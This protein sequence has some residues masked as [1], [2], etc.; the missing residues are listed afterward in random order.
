LPSCWLRRLAA[1]GVP[2]R[3]R[4][5]LP[6]Q[7]SASG[8]EI[9]AG[10]SVDMAAL[11]SIWFAPSLLERGL[12]RHEPCHDKHEVRGQLSAY[13]WNNT[14]GPGLWKWSHYFDVYEEHLGRIQCSK[15]PSRILEMGV[16]SG[17]SLKMWR[18]FFGARARIYALDISPRTKA[19]ERNDSYGAPNA[20]FVGSQADPAVWQQV[21]AVEKQLD[22]ILDDAA[23]TAE[24]QIASLKLGFK[25][26]AA[27][28]VYIVEDLAMDTHFSTYV[29]RHFVT[30]DSGGVM[31]YKALRQIV[32]ERERQEMGMD[33]KA[34]LH[35]GSTA[36][37]VEKVT[38]H[39]GIAV[40]TK[41]R[42]PLRAITSH[43]L[44]SVWEPPEFWAGQPLG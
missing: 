15:R 17:G 10:Q 2:L 31:Q 11:L 35:S 20:V 33:M 39:P 4:P 38:F 29:L 44:G 19:F 28:G 41:R 16:Y 37:A 34:R 9:A 25:L 24:L 32:S 22:V 18:W 23:H 36:S 43:R 8:R 40:I 42:V 1:V 6:R 21:A 3:P 30:G 13:F 27:G 14:V 26:L 12:L 7:S 5:A